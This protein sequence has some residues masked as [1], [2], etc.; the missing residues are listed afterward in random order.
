VTPLRRRITTTDS[1]PNQQATP[2]AAA[3]H[4][5]VEWESPKSLI[6]YATKKA[7]CRAATTTTTTTTT[8]TM[9]QP[10]T[11]LP[12]ANPPTPALLPNQESQLQL[13]KSSS[14]SWSSPAASALNSHELLQ[15]AGSH[16]SVIMVNGGTVVESPV[17][18]HSVQIL[19][20]V[21]NFG[22]L[23]R[24]LQFFELPPQTV[25]YLGV[26][27]GL[28]GVWRNWPAAKIPVAVS[29]EKNERR[30]TALQ[31]E[32]SETQIANRTLARSA[33]AHNILQNSKPLFVTRASVFEAASMEMHPSSSS[34]SDDEDSSSLVGPLK[35]V[36][37]GGSD[38]S[39]SQA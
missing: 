30:P 25:G 2:A 24:E 19:S 8:T 22:I 31:K 15:W 12:T 1:S 23:G 36:V 38:A 26:I 20:N 18:F 35:A 34:S 16:A 39:A 13:W 14:S 4:Y 10:T 3:S 9:E 7:S 28:I 5:S 29:L 17:F 21:C 37:N 11:S 27:V 32:R 6:K 33:S